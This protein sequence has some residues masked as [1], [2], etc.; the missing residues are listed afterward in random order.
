MSVHLKIQYVDYTSDRDIPVV[1][2]IWVPEDNRVLIKRVLPGDQEVVTDF[3]FR[4]IDELHST[5][6]MGYFDNLYEY[7]VVDGELYVTIAARVDESTPLPSPSYQERSV[8][9]PATFFLATGESDR[10]ERATELPR[11]LP[12]VNYR[13]RQELA[14]AGIKAW[15]SQKVDWL[16]DAQKYVDL[17]PELPAHVGYW[18]RSADCVLKIFYQSDIDPLI[19]RA[20]ARQASLGPAG[21]GNSLGL[22]RSIKEVIAR[23]PSGP[24]FAVL[25][26]ET[27][28]LQAASDVGR[29]TLPQVLQTRDTENDETYLLPTQYDSTDESWLVLDE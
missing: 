29:K 5:S 9:P 3:D 26:V 23:Y 21:V 22:F 7:A 13:Q 25:W 4:G 19:V 14:I 16:L 11:W 20:M 12:M 15:R 2:K 24:D 8:D 18:L 10:N 1:K 28:D 17:H 6:G 27:R